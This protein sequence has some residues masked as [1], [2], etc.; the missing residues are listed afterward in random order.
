MSRRRSLITLVERA[1]P[2]LRRAL[3]QDGIEAS[4][5]SGE[6]AVVEVV[7]ADS[8][9]LPVYVT[10]A[11]EQLLCISYLWRERDIRPERRG[12]LLETLLELNP[13]VPLS[14]FGRLG[15]HYVLIGALGPAST[16]ADLALELATLADNGRDAL[17]TLADYLK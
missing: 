17:A 7:F 15:E 6:V 2:A 4:T 1:L 5:L 14:A 8:D 10:D 16:A 11:G 3:Q 13:S 9:R 12:E